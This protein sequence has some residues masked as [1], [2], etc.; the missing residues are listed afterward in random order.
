MLLR[1]FLFA[2]ILVGIVMAGLA[3][4]ARADF[5]IQ[6]SYGGATITLDGTTATTSTSGGASTSG[7]LIDYSTPGTISV[8]TLR[9]SPTGTTGG[10]TISATIAESNSPGTPGVA[11][12]DIESLIIQNQTGA[13]N[14]T[15]TITSG[16]TGFTA[17]GGSPF[18]NVW[19]TSTMSA[20]TSGGNSSNATVVFNSYLD[21]TNTQFGTQQGTPTINLVNIAPGT[22]QS[23]TT[24]ALL[25]ANPTPYSLTQVVQ[26]TLASGNKLTDGSGGTT[27]TPTPEPSSLVLAG[28]GLIGLIGYGWTRRRAVALP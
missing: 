21:N 28:L 16:D 27:V 3:P 7:A 22:S 26:V 14:K 25:N 19:V 12:I 1:K 9:V 15:L 4:T 10:F 13:N 8:S 11:F 17:P 2:V 18:P 20:T 6:L 23:L 5:E 24:T